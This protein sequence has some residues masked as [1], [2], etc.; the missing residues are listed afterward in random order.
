M[1]FTNPHAFWALLALAPL[2]LLAFLRR[3]PRRRLVGSLFI[4]DQ[5]AREAEPPRRR[6]FLADLFLLLCVLAFVAAVGAW[7]GPV[8][9][10]D[11][12][13]G[14]RWMVIV[15]RSASTGLP[16]GDGSGTP[17]ALIAA[18]VDRFLAALPADDRVR[19]V[20]TPT[21]TAMADLGF[22]T[23]AAWRA[24]AL[25]APG[26]E[27]Q[28]D[29]AL[30]A[31]RRAGT[32][33]AL[34]SDRL[35]GDRRPGEIHAAYGS[36]SPPGAPVGIVAAELRDHGGGRGEVFARIAARAGAEMPAESRIEINGRAAQPL[37]GSRD[38]FLAAVEIAP[39][40]PV[41]IRVAGAPAEAFDA[42]VRFECP[43][44]ARVALAG[45]GA[46]D[47]LLRVLRYWPFLEVARSDDGGGAA[48][49]LA[50][51]LAGRPAAA[52]SWGENASRRLLGAS[53]L[54]HE[55][56]VALPPGGTWQLVDPAFSDLPVELL[57]EAGFPTVRAASPQNERRRPILRYF[58]PGSATGAGADLLWAEPGGR[59]DSETFR[60]TLDG[61][62][63]AWRAHESYP[64]F[65]TA[66]FARLLDL[67]PDP[68]RTLPPAAATP[69]SERESVSRRDWRPLE[70]GEVATPLPAS[71]GQNGQA[72]SVRRG[73]DGQ[74]T[75]VDGHGASWGL[76]AVLLAALLVIA[77]LA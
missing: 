39:G 3:R 42:E 15:D 58:A 54:P 65:F 60:L 31:A 21:P 9:R 32:R 13:A 68:W 70:E 45:G 19:L 57:A 27:D 38:A 36:P 44:P 67:G 72:A 22:A 2:L 40:R 16:G 1:I 12:P 6:R 49:A 74:A 20:V 5:V 61:D 59:S 75:S 18:A 17:A 10:S 4:W 50:I 37:P 64:A 25:P 51:D 24:A 77:R 76:P 35:A 63:A 55:A 30:D 48:V 69:L 14:V 52:P 43:P 62:D 66:L 7:A 47:T 71:P 26:G 11:A 53:S 29:V 34:F 56:L 41:T 46:N 33:V 23:P 8:R 73:Q 28:M